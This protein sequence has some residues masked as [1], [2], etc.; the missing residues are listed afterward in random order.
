MMCG[1]QGSAKTTHSGKLAL[2]FKKQG[3][4]PL[5]V[6]CDIYR[7]AAIE[8]LKVV[9]G[10]VDV[11]VFEM[12]RTDPVEIARNAVAY[13]KDY[14]RDIVILDT[15]GRLHIDEELMAELQRVKAEVK[16]DEILLVLDAMTGQ[17]AVNVAKSFDDTLGIDGTI[18]TKLDGDTRGGAA[19][20]HPGSDRQA[21][22]ICGYGRKIRGSGAV[23]P[24]PDGFAYSGHGRCADPD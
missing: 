4:R 12:G 14:G 9:G 21:H 1:L 17:D 15:A 8:Q 19:L 16:P 13:A 7:P 20:S 10:K 3:K 11:P 6:A 5:L 23:F 24:G 22:Q 2:H 18:L